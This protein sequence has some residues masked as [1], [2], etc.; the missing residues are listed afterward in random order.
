MGASRYA[1]RARCASAS[2]T[3]AP[4]RCSTWPRA[5]A[6]KRCVR[7]RSSRCLTKRCSWLKRPSACA[8]ARPGSTGCGARTPQ[9]QAHRGAARGV[10]KRHSRPPPRT[11]TVAPRTGFQGAE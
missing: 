8:R 10:P 7:A 1:A 3:R 5:A 2:T 11:P 4:E 9:C 6:A